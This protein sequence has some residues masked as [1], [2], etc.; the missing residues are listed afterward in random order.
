MVHHVVDATLIRPE[1]LLVGTG[2]G[3][4]LTLFVNYV[5]PLTGP[6]QPTSTART[7]YGHLGA[8]DEY[9]PTTKSTRRI[10]AKGLWPLARAPTNPP[11][12][13]VYSTWV[14]CLSAIQCVDYTPSVSLPLLPGIMAGSNQYSSLEASIPKSNIQGIR[15][16]HA[17]RLRPRNMW[18][19]SLAPP[20]PYP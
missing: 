3:T 11:P 2:D 16:D 9:V 1:P 10:D 6:S 4:R 13:A 19:C 12:L 5:I 7:R 14:P 20:L 15:N 8:L 18:C 17:A